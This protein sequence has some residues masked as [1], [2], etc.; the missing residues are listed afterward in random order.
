MDDN[1]KQLKWTDHLSIF[2]RS[3]LLQAGWNFKSMLSIGFVFALLPVA[4][5]LYK[6]NEERKKFLLRHI[7]FFNAHPYF[8]SYALG[9]IAKIEEETV[10]S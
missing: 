1:T 3:F 7:G 5:R 10:Q 6:T 9:A 8:A 2:F 4:K